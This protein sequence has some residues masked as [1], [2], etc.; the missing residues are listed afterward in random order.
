MP[1]VNCWPCCVVHSQ[2]WTARKSAQQGGDDGPNSDEEAP[3]GLITRYGIFEPLPTKTLSPRKPLPPAPSR[4]QHSKGWWEV[5][6]GADVG[7]HP[8][9]H[10]SAYWHHLQ[11]AV[12]RRRIREGRPTFEICPGPCT[13]GRG[14][15]FPFP[16]G[17]YHGHTPHSLT[18]GCAPIEGLHALVLPPSQ[19]G[20]G[21]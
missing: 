15:T 3:I 20:I 10:S 1:G 12:F 7:D 14:S 6:V 4:P 11:V 2:Q 9:A 21:C 16:S 17:K 18:L 5:G 19:G 8:C 13:H